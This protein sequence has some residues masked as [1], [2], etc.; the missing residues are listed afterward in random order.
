MAQQ[1][2]WLDGC[3]W[4]TRGGEPQ[5]IMGGLVVP[6]SS[7]EFLRRGTGA[8]FTWLCADAMTFQAPSTVKSKQDR[9]RNDEIYF[10]MPHMDIQQRS[11]FC[12]A[13][14]EAPGKA[15]AW[16][17]RVF[18]GLSCLEVLLMEGHLS[19]PSKPRSPTSTGKC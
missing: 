9:E 1:G 17:N 6:E 11:C 13:S 15:S 5:E 3:S 8:A 16:W 2:H 10:V 18:L 19:T 12:L 7:T 4:N 14:G